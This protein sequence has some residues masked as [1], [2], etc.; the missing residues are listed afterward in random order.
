MMQDI[1]RRVAVV[2][3]A[4]RGI[5]LAIT[6]TLLKRGYLV[7][8]IAR[9]RKDLDLVREQYDPSGERTM[10]LTCD[11]GDAEQVQDSIDS[12]VSGWKRIDVLVNNAG[13]GFYGDVKDFPDEQW[14]RTHDTNLKGP[15]NCCRAVIPIMEKQLSGHIIF[16]SS[17]SDRGNSPYIASKRGLEGFA[18]SLGYELRDK[19]IQVSVIVPGEM[20]KSLFDS[21]GKADLS[22]GS[23]NWSAVPALEVA[24]VV[25]ETVE[26]L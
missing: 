26:R 18:T 11:V 16:V 10:I 13:V 15:F 17:S 12:V 1:H 23:K 3:G 2:T 7:A 6:E 4:S 14:E 24:K 22:G 25:L 5:G 21:P 8:C 19:G 9:G 20:D